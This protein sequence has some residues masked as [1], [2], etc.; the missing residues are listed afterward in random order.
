MLGLGGLGGGGSCCSSSFES[1]LVFSK[2]KYPLSTRVFRP[3]SIRSPFMEL[4]SKRWKSH[5]AWFE[6]RVLLVAK[7]TLI[8]PRMGVGNESRDG[9]GPMHMLWLIL[10]TWFLHRDHSR[11]P[12]RWWDSLQGAGDA[13]QPLGQAC[14]I[15]RHKSSNCEMHDSHHH[16]APTSIPDLPRLA[17]TAVL[18]ARGDGHLAPGSQE[19]AENIPHPSGQIKETATA[20]GTCPRPHRKSPQPLL[21]HG[22]Q[23][24]RRPWRLPGTH[25]GDQM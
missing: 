24:S 15:E 3:Q 11:C 8:P 25:Q 2:E 22:E 9:L 1:C 21:F 16:S 20:R 19:Q 5:H 18:Q 7:I 23:C 4:S 12:W 14:K 6:V 17:P 10:H 13:S